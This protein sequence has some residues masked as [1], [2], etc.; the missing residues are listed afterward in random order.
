MRLTAAIATS[1]L[2]STAY[3]GGISPIVTGGFH[4]ETVPYYSNATDGGNGVPL[5]DPRTYP[6]FNQNQLIGNLGAGI[7]F[8]LGNQ[9]NPIRGTF[10]A[11]W[12]RDFPQSDPALT[13]TDVN[14]ANIVSP[15]RSTSQDYFLVTAGLQWSVVDAADGRFRFG[16]ELHV[17][18]PVVGK[19][20]ELFLL[21]QPGVFASFSI[22]RTLEVYVDANYTFRLTKSVSH[23][24]LAAT[25]IR[26]M[27][28]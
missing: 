8:M 25:G 23:G 9:D 22:N 1:L 11:M 14:P 7:E 12:F 26:V 21:A 24:F 20:T 3:A 10:R 13:A 16:P 19:M 5:D 28:D 17:G 18:A 4:T 6:Q 2:A 27:F 15:Y